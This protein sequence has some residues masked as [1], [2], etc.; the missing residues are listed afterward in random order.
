MGWLVTAC[1]VVWACGEANPS[2]SGRRLEVPP[3]P[4]GRLFTQLP[5]EYTGVFFENRLADTPELNVFTYRNY[6]NGGGVAL[7]DLTGDGLPELVL[8]ANLTGTRVYLNEGGFRFRDITAAARVRG[9]RSW[10]TGVTLADVNGDGWLDIYVCYA[11]LGEPEARANEL[12]LHQGMRGN[13]LPLF[14]EAAAE[15]GIADAGYGTHAAFFDYDRDGDLDLYIVNNSPRPVSTLGPEHTRDVRDPYG[16]DKLYR[17]D[18]GRFSDVSAAAGIYGSEIG[19]GLGVAVGDF[20]GDG[21]PDIYVANDFF[22]RDYLYLNRR[23]GTFVEVLEEQMPSI[24]YSSMGLDL[25]DINNDGWLDLFVADMLPEDNYRLKA[26]TS[27]ENWTQYLDRVRNGYHHQFTRNTLQLNHG[28]GTFSEIGMLA[29][30]GATDWSW[31]ALLADF[32]LD[33]YKDLYVTNG[34]P[35]DVTLQDYLVFLS[36]N[37]TMAQ[38]ARGKRVDFQWLID[39]MT[40]TPLRNYAFRND[41]N[42]TFSNVSAEWGLDLEGFSSGAAYGDLDGDG[43]LDLVINNTNGKASLYR[44]NARTI[45]GNRY[46]QVVLEGERSNRF[47]VGARVTV[48]SGGRLQVQELVPARGFQSSVDYVMTFGLGGRGAVDSLTVQWPDGRVSTRSSVAVDQRITIRQAQA[49]SDKKEPR[50]AVTPLVTDVTDEIGIPF[51]HRE[52]ESWEFD[53]Q[54]LLPKTLA[55]EGPYA[56]VGD[57]NGDGRDDFFIGGAKDQPGSL[58]LQRPEGRFSSAGTA[59]FRLDAVSEDVGAVFLDATGDGRPDLYVVSGGSEFTDGAPG[60][61]DRLYVNDA[62]RGLLKGDGYLP[63]MR[64]SGSRA[65]AADFDGDGDLDLFVGGRVVPWRYGLDPPSRLLANDGRGRF[66]DVTA[67]VAPGLE[68]VGMVTDALW[69]DTDGDGLVDLVIVGEWMPITI[70][71]NLGRGRLRRQ[72]V[73][74]LE[75]SHGWWNRIVAGDFTGDGRVDFVAG[76]AGINMRFRASISRPLTLYVKDFDRNGFVEPV[77]AQYEGPISYPL[78]LRD[79]LLRALPVLKARFQTYESYARQSMSDI[80]GA[81]EL[82][83]AVIK[84]AYTFESV[85]VRNNGD[86]TFRM[87]PLPIEAQFAPVYGMLAEDVD[88]NGTLDVLLA[89][90]LDGVK[91]EYGRMHASYGLVLSGDGRGGF[92][93]LSGSASGFV[94]PGQARDIQRLRTPGGVLYLVTRNNDRPLVFRPARDRPRAAGSGY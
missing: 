67:E 59:L 10:V 41:G 74:G 82:E 50:S 36:R 54:P 40:S 30:V 34:I 94:V 31:S 1:G 69:Q 93:P 8:T 33:G 22:E 11:G 37:E 88:G 25:A 4:N 92:T 35:R 27:F 77:V 57:V 18:G 38:A 3:A 26:T 86:G 61:Q 79:D 52:S 7:G 66:K 73:P 91:P 24:S 87:M 75:H 70:F 6:Y 62:L 5:A 56:A 20:N 80:F 72:S 84:R 85:L 71:R 29:G 76:N 16:G 48:H 44:N 32:D 12:Y 58:F 13:G 78:A 14:R 83:G 55:I 17:N 68:Q 19:F 46:L 15:Y 28:N 90:N 89:G 45:L 21:W 2:T 65:A 81:A 64:F 23:D 51:V 9:K 42:L 39:A 53:R 49:S 63:S 60:L 43:A 47:A